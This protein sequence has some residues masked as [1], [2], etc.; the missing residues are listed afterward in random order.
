M[1]YNFRKSG[2]PFG[3]IMPGNVKIVRYVHIYTARFA[4]PLPEALTVCYLSIIIIQFDGTDELN[5]FLY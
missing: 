5:Y 1:A 4:F 3:E 2:K